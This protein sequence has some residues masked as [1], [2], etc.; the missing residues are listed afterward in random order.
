MGGQ[1]NATAILPARKTRY[2]LYR[3]LGGTQGW[4]ER[5][6]KI[7]PTPEINPRTDRYLASRYRDC[8]RHLPEGLMLD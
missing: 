4:S 2:I 8:F 1:R 7:S 3:G 6:G 5:V